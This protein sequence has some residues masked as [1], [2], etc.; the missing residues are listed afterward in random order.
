[1]KKLIT[2]LFSLCLALAMAL[3]ALATDY[4]VSMRGQSKSLL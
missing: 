2:T 4:R 3:P 1:M